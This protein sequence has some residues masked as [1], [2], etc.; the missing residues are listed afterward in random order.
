MT[1]LFQ[2]FVLAI[3]IA[4]VLA[5]IT[6]W[7]RRRVWIK[8]F[9][10]AVAALYMPVAYAGFS[11]LLSKPK[12]VSLEWARR[13]DSEATVLSAIMKEGEGI[14]LWL[15]LDGVT[16]PRSYVLPWDLETAKELQEAMREAEANQNGLRMRLPFAQSFDPD[17]PKFYAM[18]Q[19]ELPSKDESEEP[20][21]YSHPSFE[22]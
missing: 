18:P 1:Q 10:V 21:V 22:A 5:T 20:T 12:P 9:A 15:R 2:L 13:A 4:V 11:D 8:V 16:E 14:Y 19:P 6:V 7:S 17:E 3:G